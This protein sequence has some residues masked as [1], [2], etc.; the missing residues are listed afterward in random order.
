MIGE[1]IK[2]SES[3]LE[4]NNYSPEIMSPVSTKLPLKRK[5]WANNFS[6]HCSS[7]VRLE[8]QNSLR[9]FFLL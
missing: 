9:Y 5:V 6:S 7:T 8:K 2:Q 1:K 3:E 4:E